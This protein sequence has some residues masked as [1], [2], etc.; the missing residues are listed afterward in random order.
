LRSSNII[1]SN[2]PLCS[3]AF[4]E[5]GVCF[6][7]SLSLSNVLRISPP[8]RPENIVH[9]TMPT[10]I[11]NAKKASSINRIM[12]L[13]RF[14]LKSVL[15]NLLLVGMIVGFLASCSTP[16]APSQDEIL[17][18]IQADDGVLPAPIL[19]SKS[20]WM[21]VRWRELPGW[22]N[23]AAIQNDAWA[24]WLKSCQN[25]ATANAYLCPEIRSLSMAS[26]NEQR[27][28]MMQKLQPYRVESLQGSAEGLL[29][30]YYEPVL[31]A[32]RKPRLGFSVPLY[33]PPAGLSGK[34]PW[35]TRQEMDTSPQVKAQLRGL[36]IAYVADPIDALILHIQGSGRVKMLEAD[37]SKRTVRFAYAA[38]NEQPYK[39]VGRW[40]LD[41]GAAGTRDVS[42][43][44]IKTWLAR[45]QQRLNELLWSN[46]R[47]VFFREEAMPDVQLGPKGAQGVPLTPGRSIAVD[48]ASIPYGAPVWIASGGPE[49]ESQRFQKLVLAQDTGGAILGAVRADYFMGWGQEAGD[50]AGR[51]KQPLQMW[52]LWPKSKP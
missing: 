52:V 17:P 31:E 14:V 34:S 45:N 1:A 32:S 22:N 18:T 15:Q 29:T 36:E 13:P 38:T 2:S 27:A 4:Y 3:I 39:S 11:N 42:W 44:G 6:S 8:W 37:G 23:P 30:S 9:H 41:Q 43:P 25:A 50:A 7:L 49:G 33:R 24:A 19:Q 46:P 28:W 47:V 40:L 16:L 20:R 21:P 48:R 35:Y 12:T 26:F 10:K 51:I 5:D